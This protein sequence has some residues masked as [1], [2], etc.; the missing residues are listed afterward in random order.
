VQFYMN[1]YQTGNPEIQP[2]DPF[3]H[4]TPELPESV[5]VLVAG[6]GPAGLMNSRPTLT[7]S[8]IDSPKVEM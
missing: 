6:S 8:T 5:D 2:A 1:G 4:W 3:N 7:V